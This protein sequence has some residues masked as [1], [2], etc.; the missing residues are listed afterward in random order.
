MVLDFS[1][2]R[3]Y[4]AFNRQN[5][6]SLS[7][8]V[9]PTDVVN[10]TG[11]PNDLIDLAERIKQATEKQAAVIMFIGAH[12]IKCGLSPFVIDLIKQGYL[13]HIAGNGA[14]S[15]HDFEI[16]YL[17]ATSEDV[18]NAINDGSFGM[19]EETCGWM[20]SA[21]NE[22]ATNGYGH[23]IASYMDR[24]LVKFPN[25]KHSVVYTAYK[26]NVPVTIHVTIGADI[27]H[28]HS[29]A[30][31]GAIG[32]ASGNDFYKFCKS[33]SNLEGGVFMN[34]GSA[35]TGAEVFLKALSISRNLGFPTK[36]ITTANFDLHPIGDCKL[37]I[38]NSDPNY[39][40]RP[41]KNIVNRPT[42]KGGIGYNF[43]LDHRVS[44]P[45][46]HA[47]LTKD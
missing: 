2:I 14:T 21:I 27:I 38:D 40:Y 10:I 34:F 3:T 28:Q 11:V 43:E 44:I 30:N 41:R 29:T 46:L 16:S 15:I 1:K 7:D 36:E 5:L 35:V 8:L 37:C 32:V 26:N 39:Y 17:G 12:V 47:L 22:D 23:A 45:M 9:F 13:S 42:Q 20:N 6:V 25:T 31:F 24:H 18:P 19:W 33:V 4:S